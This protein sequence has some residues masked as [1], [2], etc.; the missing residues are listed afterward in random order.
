MLSCCIN[1]H[2]NNLHTCRHNKAIYTLANTI[3]AHPITWCFTLI[4]AGKFKARTPENTIP[5]WLLP[6]TCYLSRCICPARLRP[7]TLCILGAPSTTNPP[8][9][10]AQISKYKWSNPH[11]TA[12]SSMQK[13]QLANWKICCLPPT[14]SPNQIGSTTA[15]HHHNMNLRGHTHNNLWTPPKRGVLSC[16]RWAMSGERWAV[17]CEQWGSWNIW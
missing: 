7:D 6:C 10:L 1:K 14:L 15:R 8:L 5:S 11:T 9:C 2:I 13:Q 17:T 16:E 12:T 3:L 4:N